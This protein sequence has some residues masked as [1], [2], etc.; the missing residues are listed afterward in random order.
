VY[1]SEGANRKIGLMPFCDIYGQGRRIDVLQSAMKRER[2]PHAYLFHGMQGVGKRTTAQALAQALNC[3]ENNADFCGRCPSCLK[4]DH[5][6]H[7]DIGVIEPEGI[8][9]KIDRI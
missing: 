6:N 3:R 2:V 5:R 4:A 8:F 9:I 7:P 1:P